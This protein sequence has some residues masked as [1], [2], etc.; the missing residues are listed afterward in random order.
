MPGLNIRNLD[1]EV[2]EALKRRASRHHRS[3]HGEI[4][5]IL[6]EAAATQPPAET[7][8]PLKLVY[9]KGTKGNGAN[10]SR[11]FLYDDAR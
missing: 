2:L 7:R 4:H 10:W 1:S 3:L 9:A 6:R 11:D 8:K 5:A